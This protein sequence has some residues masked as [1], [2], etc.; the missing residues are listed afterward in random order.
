MGG[1]KKKLRERGRERERCHPSHFSPHKKE[2]MAEGGEDVLA[3]AAAA[4]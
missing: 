1:K 4:T 3:E 2:A